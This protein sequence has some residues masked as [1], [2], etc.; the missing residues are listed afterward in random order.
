MSYLGI[1]FLILAAWYI[2]NDLLNRVERRKLINRIM[3][4]NYREFEYFDKKFQNDVKTTREAEKIM[5]QPEEVVPGQ[6]E[7]LT[8]EDRQFLRGMDED[9]P[10]EVIDNKRLREVIGESKKYRENDLIK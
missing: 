3:A 2:V 6:T 5:M 1:G 4:R 7:E 8:P 9:W 10:E